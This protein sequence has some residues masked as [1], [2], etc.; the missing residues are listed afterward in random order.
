MVLTIGSLVDLSKPVSSASEEADRYYTLA[1][2]AIMLESPFD[3]G[4]STAFVQA[5]N[6]MVCYR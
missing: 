2:A 5:L 6:M 1:K 4:T 3:K